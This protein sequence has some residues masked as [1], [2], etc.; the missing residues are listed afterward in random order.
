MQL[1]QAWHDM[2]ANVDG[3]GRDAV[4]RPWRIAVAECQLRDA[5]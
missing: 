3:A 4:R 2:V 1:H 5:G